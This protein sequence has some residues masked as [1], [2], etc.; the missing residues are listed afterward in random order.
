MGTSTDKP[1]DIAKIDQSAS[2]KV[3]PATPPE[4]EA[5]DDRTVRGNPADRKMRGNPADRK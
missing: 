5:G 3:P 1:S 2:G 4:H